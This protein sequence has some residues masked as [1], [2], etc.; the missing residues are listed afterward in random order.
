MRT[1]S[2][3]E[4]R[5]ERMKALHT[6][7]PRNPTLESH[8]ER[9]ES[10]YLLLAHVPECPSLSLSKPSPSLRTRVQTAS[11]KTTRGPGPES[12]PLLRPQSILRAPELGKSCLCCSALAPRARPPP[13]PPAPGMGACGCCLTA[14]GYLHSF[15]S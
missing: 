3:G 10:A 13:P 4:R 7:T 9:S 1:R 14:Q 6:L 8:P 11:G 2:L 5:K 12:Q 15:P